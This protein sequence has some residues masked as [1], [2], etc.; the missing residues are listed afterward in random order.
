[1]KTKRL[2][3]TGCLFFFF[4]YAMSQVVYLPLNAIL[5]VESLSLCPELI[6]DDV[7]DLLDVGETLLKSIHGGSLYKF[8]HS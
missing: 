3:V 6:C 5:G 7:T 8:M 1:M 4:L 2:I